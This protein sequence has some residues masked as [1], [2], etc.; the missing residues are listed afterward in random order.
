MNNLPCCFLAPYTYEWFVMV[1]VFAQERVISNIGFAEF[2]YRFHQQP[3]SI[4]KI[5]E[6]NI[7]GWILDSRDNTKLYEVGHHSVVIYLEDQTPYQSTK[8]EPCRG[9]NSKTSRLFRGITITL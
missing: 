5:A 1:L 7:S 8:S 6:H 3:M 2:P 4:R 9:A